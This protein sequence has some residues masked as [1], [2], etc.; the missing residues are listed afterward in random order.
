MYIGSNPFKFLGRQL[1]SSVSEDAA[2]AKVLKAVEDCTRKIDVL[3]LL[4]AH[5]IWI[6]DAVLMSM[7]SWDL[8]I[9]D[10]RVTFVQQL[11]DLQMRM[12]KKLA[13][14]PGVHPFKSSSEALRSGDWGSRKWCLSSRSSNYSS[15][16]C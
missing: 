1:R 6:F 13:S 2:K 5:K 3:P 4:G 7:I 8:M 14:M 10:M 11:G 9:H 12:Y 16:T 15:G